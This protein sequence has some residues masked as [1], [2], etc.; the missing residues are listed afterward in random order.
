MLRDKIE[1]KQIMKRI[2][3]IKR[4]RTKIK[5]KKWNKMLRTN[6]KKKQIKKRKKKEHD[7]NEKK[8]EEINEIKCWWTKLKGKK[9]QEKD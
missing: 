4:M 2:K 6:W 8:E 3:K 1:R 7:Q 5:L 9:N